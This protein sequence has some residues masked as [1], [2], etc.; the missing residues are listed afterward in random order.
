MLRR[1]IL[2]LM[3]AGVAGVMVLSSP[4]AASLDGEVTQ[5]RA[6]SEGA[7]GTDAERRTPRPM[8][9]YPATSP[10]PLRAAVPER[11]RP[12]PRPTTTSPTPSPTTISPSPSAPATSPAPSATPTPPAPSPS[13]TA[14]ACAVPVVVFNGGSY[15]PVS[16]P[17]VRATAHGTGA[18]VALMSVTVSEVTAGTVTV[19]VWALPPCPPDKYCGATMTLQSVTVSWQGAGRPAY[20]D[21]LN[22]F[23]L[24]APGSLTP[25]GY[26]KTGYCPIDMC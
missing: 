3:S 6:G 17:Q 5:A 19:A 7:N 18:R 25:A 24:T 15:C 11:R 20:G 26:I 1:S 21:V 4:T 14:I 23:G 9:T 16:I 8:P 10:S 13:V 2:A 12:R 22:L